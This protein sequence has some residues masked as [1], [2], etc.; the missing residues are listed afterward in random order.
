MC[1]CKDRDRTATVTVL[2]AVGA[3]AGAVTPLQA[4]TD[5]WADARSEMVR[6]QIAGDRGGRTPVTDTD[7]LRAMLRVPRHRFVPD[8]QVR[9]AYADSPLPIG[10][11]QTI[12]QPYIVALM[13]ELLDVGEGD[14]VLEIGTGSGYQAAVLAEIVDSV[15]TIEI[16]PELATGARQR[17]ADLGYG[18]ITVR[19]GDGYY[20]WPGHEPFDA[21]VVTAAAS[22]IPPPLEEQLAPGGRMVI[23]VGPPLRVQ[24]LM[25][26][27]KLPDGSVRRRNLLPVRFVPLTRDD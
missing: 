23:P 6:T 10:Y 25:L 20:G 16:V 27:E 21:I 11:G 1:R 9:R 5:A 19:A 2:A 14:V 18:G 26:V 12:S 15:Y 22:H 3:L 13:T 7:V 17:L 8:N 24:S 4:Q